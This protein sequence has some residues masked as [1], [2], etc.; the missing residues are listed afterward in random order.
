MEPR[1][2]AATARHYKL[3]ASTGRRDLDHLIF[4]IAAFDAGSFHDRSKDLPDRNNVR[5]PQRACHVCLVGSGN[6]ARVSRQPQHTGQEV[7]RRCT[8]MVS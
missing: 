2:P 5:R 3:K 8:F 4:V 7:H 6:G 1:H